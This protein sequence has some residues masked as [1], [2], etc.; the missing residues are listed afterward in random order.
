MPES[1]NPLV[2]AYHLMWTVYSYWLPN[3]PRGSTS[4]TVRNDLIAELGELH[5]GR[6]RVQPTGREIREFASRAQGALSYPLLMFAPQELG[7]VANTIGAAV[8]ECNYTCYACAVMS[9]HVH[10]VIRKH[11]DLGEVM[12]DQLQSLS[13]ERLIEAGLRTTDH[14][15]WTRGGWKVYLEHPDDVRRTIHYVEQNP[16]KARM[17]QQ[18]WDWVTA[19]DDWPLHIGHSP[20]SPYVVA[21]KRAG[22]YPR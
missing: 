12:I 1:K 19:Y 4:Q 5:F 2:I 14:P 13:R 21:L 9:D 17:P 20:T 10:L 3:D 8:A 11:R 18:A 22:R 6:K 15:V 16:M 7:I